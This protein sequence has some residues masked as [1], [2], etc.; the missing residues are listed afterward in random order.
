[1]YTHYSLY[2]DLLNYHR[3]L[4]TQLLLEFKRE[5]EELHYKLSTRIDNITRE[6]IPFLDN[7]LRLPLK[8]IVAHSVIL[9]LREF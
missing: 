4:I 7:K 8:P 5:Q 1:M 9:M 6:D 2:L 3:K